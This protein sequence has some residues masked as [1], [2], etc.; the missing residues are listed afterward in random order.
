M[1]PFSPLENV[2]ESEDV[3]KTWDNIND[4]IKMSARGSLGLYEWKHHKPQFVEKRSRFLEQRQQV[5]TQWLQDSNE[6]NV[7]TC[8]YVICAASRDFRNERREYLKALIY[9]L[10]TYSKNKIIRDLCRVISDIKKV[11]SLELI[12]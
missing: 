10:Q 1:K 8:K 2:S 9:E 12:L 3:N 5:K 4:H 6:S 11:P 7:A